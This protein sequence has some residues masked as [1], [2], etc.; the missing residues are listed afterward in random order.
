MV[1]TV[2]GGEDCGDGNGDH[3][4]GGGDGNAD[5]G[6]DDPFAFAPHGRKAR[7]LVTARQNPW[8]RWVVVGSGG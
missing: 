3:D 4:G 1:T 2:S 5:S 7:L 6:D 8:W